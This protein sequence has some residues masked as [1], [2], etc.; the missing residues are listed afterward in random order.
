MNKG[1]IIL[2]CFLVLSFLL[3]FFRLE[4]P[5]A[6]DGSTTVFSNPSLVI[7]DGVGAYECGD[8]VE[9]I[10]YSYG[11][12]EEAVVLGVD[13][14]FTISYPFLSELVVILQ[15]SDDSSKIELLWNMDGEDSPYTKNDIW[16]FYGMKANTHWKLK[17][18]DCF[19]GYS[20]AT[21]VSWSLT[22]HYHVPPDPPAFVWG[23]TGTGPREINLHWS[24]VFDEQCLDYRIEGNRNKSA[25][26]DSNIYEVSGS[27]YDCITTSKTIHNLACADTYYFQVRTVS[28][29]QVLSRPSWPLAGVL[30]SYCDS[31][32][33]WGSLNYVN[34]DDKY[35]GY[36][37]DADTIPLPNALVTIW[38]SVSGDSIPIPAIYTN[39]FF[40]L[41]D[42]LLH[43]HVNYPIYMR[44]QLVDQSESLV[45]R[46]YD[47]PSVTLFTYSDTL[48][49]DNFFKVI[50]D[51]FLP[52]EQDTI[53]ARASYSFDDIQKTKIMF[54]NEAS[55]NTPIVEVK[56]DYDNFTD[57][58]ST[59]YIPATHEFGM[60]LTSRGEPTFC[61]RLGA[62][63]HEFAHIIHFK[64][65]NI[66][67]PPG[68]PFIHSP[69]TRTSG[70]CALLEGWAEFLE[71]IFKEDRAKYLKYNQQDLEYNDWW[72]GETGT[73][74]NGFFV[75]GAVASA[76]YDMEDLNMDYPDERSQT[77]YYELLYEMSKIFDIFR[78]QKPQNITDFMDY[79]QSYPG[80]EEWERTNLIKIFDQHYIFKPGD[81]NSDGTVT[82]ADVV[83]LV[84]FLFKG[85]PPPSPLWRGDANGDCQV[86]VAD[87]VYLVAYLFKQ[88]AKPFFNQN[89]N[90]WP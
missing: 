78:N 27:V 25:L 74:T 80:L 59:Y 41:I 65:W 21:L 38:E 18:R 49:P 86:T 28:I 83:F 70:Y 89:P 14:S 15:Y 56:Y 36:T 73:N 46:D 69:D 82:V 19:F 45:V 30:S 39:T 34:Y 60:H 68:C 40:G 29:Y 4:M 63:V 10:V 11:L 61:Y 13:V 22:V 44:F 7:P 67:S 1:K 5:K 72:Q 53:F 35:A 24:Q 20:G 75:E 50:R 9:D 48:G 62:P 85:G 26:A 81:A 64:S 57:L 33:V 90:C 37:Y 6:Y 55:W 71:C 17:L 77:E 88:G 47:N 87:T 52:F 58:S 12:P 32:R 42:T 16:S 76:W 3:F 43:Y 23:Y 2:R 84:S 54:K 31:F 79:W 8:E 51:E 66:T